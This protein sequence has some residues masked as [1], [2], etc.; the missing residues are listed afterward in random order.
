MPSHLGFDAGG[1][2]YV[3]YGNV[4][5]PSDVVNGAIHKYDPRS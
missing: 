2:L 1:E 5:G 4:P 3:S